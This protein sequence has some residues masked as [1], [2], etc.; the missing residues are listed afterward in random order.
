MGGRKRGSRVERYLL[1]YIKKGTLE[2]R[3]ATGDKK[4]MKTLF[5]QQVYIRLTDD[6][7]GFVCTVKYGGYTKVTEFPLHRQLTSDL[8]VK[9][10]V[11]ARKRSSRLAASEEQ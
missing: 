6:M 7:S 11:L 2:R 4:T 1:T 8:D 9:A 5:E 3:H 10:L